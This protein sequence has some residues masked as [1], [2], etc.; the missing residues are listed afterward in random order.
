MH[1][2][3]LVSF[4]Y[5]YAKKGCSKIVSNYTQINLTNLYKN[6]GGKENARQAHA[7]ANTVYNKEKEKHCTW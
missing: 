7:N 4:D 5:V 1:F 6:N 3:D 2:K